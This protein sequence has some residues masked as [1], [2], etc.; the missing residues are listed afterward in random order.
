MWYGHRQQ[1]LASHP[2]LTVADYRLLPTLIDSAIRVVQI[3]DERLIFYRASDGSLM[4]A[5]VRYDARESGPYVV[6]F[7]RVQPRDMAAQSRKGDV[8]FS[9]DAGS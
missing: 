4:R 5:V 6:S 7:H 2:E 3:G 8:L 9:S 1:Q